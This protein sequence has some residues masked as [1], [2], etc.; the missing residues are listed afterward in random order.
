MQ[1]DSF[2]HSIS[3]IEAKV[4]HAQARTS[5]SDVKAGFSNQCGMQST[6]FW[7]RSCLLVRMLAYWCVQS[8]RRQ[9]ADLHQVVCRRIYSCTQSMSRLLQ[10]PSV[11]SLS[12]ECQLAPKVPAV[13]KQMTS[14]QTDRVNRVS[15]FRML[16]SRG[17]IFAQAPSSS[18]AYM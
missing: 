11:H 18:P 8:H 17:L 3:R 4:T 14:Q 15:E 1:K 5:T 16:C 7:T 2:Y 12:N 9:L 13:T 10:F 6:C